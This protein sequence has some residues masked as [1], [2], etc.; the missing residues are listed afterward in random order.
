MFIV[1]K[2]KLFIRT[3]L[4]ISLVILGLFFTIPAVEETIN[5]YVRIDSINQREVFWESGSDVISDYPILGIGPGT[6]YQYFYSY[7]PSSLFDFFYLDIWRYGKPSPHNLF[8]YYWSENGILGF[9][10]SISLFV[11][12]FYFAANTIKLTKFKHKNNYIIS[13]AITGIGIGFL[14]RAF[15]EVTGILYYG[16]ITTDL[17]FWLLFGILIHFYQKMNLIG[18]ESIN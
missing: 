13:I 16:Y 3:F 6:F 18:C 11:L 9:I 10:L 14:F 15:F 17:P 7:A 8:L 5:L 12:F 2:W 1:I 4:I